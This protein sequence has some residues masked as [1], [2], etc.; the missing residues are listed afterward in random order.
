MEQGR[1]DQGNCKREPWRWGLARR[2]LCRPV[3]AIGRGYPDLDAQ[4]YLISTK[5]SFGLVDA[6]EIIVSEIAYE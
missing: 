6:Y 4:A 1:L 5:P 3:P 2:G